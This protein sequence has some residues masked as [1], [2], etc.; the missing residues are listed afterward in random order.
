[1]S[2]PAQLFLG[3]GS[4]VLGALCVSEITFHDN[5]NDMHSVAAGI[6][7]AALALGWTRIRLRAAG[8]IAAGLPGLFLA[9]KPWLHPIRGT[10]P[11]GLPY[12]L[13]P[14][15]ERHLYAL[16]AGLALLTLAGVLVSTARRRD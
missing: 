8:V 10:D 4:V 9:A 5:P 15:A 2:V 6:A 16:F 1:M 12:F 7:G 3:V 14:M 13:G 11:D